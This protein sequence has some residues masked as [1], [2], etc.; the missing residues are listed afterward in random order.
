[1]PIGTICT[2]HALVYSVRLSEQSPCWC[3]CCLSYSLVGL[4]ALRAPGARAAV[5]SLNDEGV[6][7]LQL[8]VHQATGPQ[9][10]L[11]RRTVQHHCFERSLQPMDV[12]RTDLP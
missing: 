9:L 7:L 5:V 10:T 12:E 1:M 8:A 6:F 3:C 4:F 2:V 11:A